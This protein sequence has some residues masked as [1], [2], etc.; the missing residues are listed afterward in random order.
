M[1]E[2]ASS[3]PCTSI[4]VPCSPCFFPVLVQHTALALQPRCVSSTGERAARTRLTIA[5]SAA[6]AAVGSRNCSIPRPRVPVADRP[7]PWCW[8]RSGGQPLSAVDGTCSVWVGR[9]VKAPKQGHGQPEPHAGRGER[10]RRPDERL[11][12]SLVSQRLALRCGHPRKTPTQLDGLRA[13]GGHGGVGSR[14]Y[15]KVSTES[16]PIW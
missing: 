13:G 9:R 14:P 2:C 6:S 16:I 5:T 1:V 8:G 11:H 15:D 7:P 10:H 4:R 12:E 3:R